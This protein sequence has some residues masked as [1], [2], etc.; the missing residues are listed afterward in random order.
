MNIFHAL[1]SVRLSGKRT[2][3]LRVPHTFV[4]SRNRILSRIAVA[5]IIVLIGGLTNAVG[6][7][8]TLI[9]D[10]HGIPLAEETDQHTVQHLRKLRD[11][12]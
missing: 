9:R 7:D 2:F 11:K 5:A 6:A 4:R 12:V 1:N 10:N 8:R 3:P